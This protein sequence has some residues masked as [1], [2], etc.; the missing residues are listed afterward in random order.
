M[1]L[2]CKFG[3]GLLFS[4]NM[5]LLSLCARYAVAALGAAKKAAPALPFDAAAATGCCLCSVPF[6]PQL[7]PVV[8]RSCLIVA[9]IC[10]VSLLTSSSGYSAA[11]CSDEEGGR[12]HPCRKL[13][14]KTHRCLK[15][16]RQ[17]L[18]SRVQSPPSR[19]T[20]LLRRRL[21]RNHG[22]ISGLRKGNSA[23]WS[24]GRFWHV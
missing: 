9:A 14:R 18:S 2:H 13:E 10:T 16:R 17:G 8:F 3:L 4:F 15:A 19:C 21:L 5:S 20:N 1:V 12:F 7:L 24:K 11:G 23:Q 6:V 22:K